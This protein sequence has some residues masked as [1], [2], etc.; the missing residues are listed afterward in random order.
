[1]VLLSSYIGA[2]TMPEAAGVRGGEK[3]GEK[4]FFLLILLRM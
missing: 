2:G 3:G 1:M 4:A